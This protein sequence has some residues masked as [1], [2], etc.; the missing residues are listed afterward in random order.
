MALHTLPHLNSIP[1]AVL[2]DL[3]VPLGSI[4]AQTPPPQPWPCLP[5]SN[6][7]W[8]TWTSPPSPG[9]PLCHSC[10][11]GWPSSLSLHSRTTPPLIQRS[12]LPPH[13]CPTL[14]V[15]LTSSQACPALFVPSASP[16][17]Y[18]VLIC[19]LGPTSRC[20]HPSLSTP[21]SAHLRPCPLLWLSPQL[22][23]GRPITHPALSMPSGP[24]GRSIPS[25][26][27]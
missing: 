9:G 14:T 26:R 21:R 5:L 4:P 7:S 19:P 10:S 22:L 11:S 20:C 3:P 17:A 18:S 16:Q 23:L 27:P 6:C 2:P 12:P 15:P 25:A 13:P 8:A 24:S 1:E